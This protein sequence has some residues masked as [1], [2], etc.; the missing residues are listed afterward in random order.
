MY[1]FLQYIKI[2][3]TNFN[4]EFQIQYNFVFHHNYQLNLTNEV[5]LTN[6]ANQPPVKRQGMSTFR[7][8][9]KK[10]QGLNIEFR[11]P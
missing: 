11:E 10:W 5:K 6:L 1:I 9:Q 8:L 3:N 7:K 2:K 4:N